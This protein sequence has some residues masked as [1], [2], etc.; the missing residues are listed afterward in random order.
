MIQYKFSKG[1]KNQKIQCC[2]PSIDVKGDIESGER[3]EAIAFYKGRIKLTIGIEASFGM[4]VEDG[5]DYTGNYL[6]NGIECK[7]NLYTEDQIFHFGVIWIE[8]YT[9]ENDHQTWYGAD[10]AMTPSLKD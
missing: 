6:S 10:P 8:P 2:L 4:E 5:Y 7:T 3:L 1:S 9:Q